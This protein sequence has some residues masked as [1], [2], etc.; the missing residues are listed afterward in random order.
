[1]PDDDKPVSEAKTE[2]PKKVFKKKTS[3]PAPERKGR[4]GLNRAK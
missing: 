4:P 3:K 2:A 1:M